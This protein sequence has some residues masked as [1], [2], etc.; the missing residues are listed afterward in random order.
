M[1]LCA[2][3][4]NT[5][6]KTGH[7]TKKNVAR[8]HQILG[9]SEHQ[10]VLGSTASRDDGRGSADSHNSVTSANHFAPVLQSD[11]HHHQ[12]TITQFLTGGM[13]FLLPTNS[14]R[15]LNVFIPSLNNCIFAFLHIVYTSLFQYVEICLTIPRILSYR[16]CCWFSMQ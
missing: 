7:F 14:I 8:F 11:H 13:P 2:G 5:M 15:E 16:V 3:K 10:T 4:F 6:W 12:N 9:K 1:L